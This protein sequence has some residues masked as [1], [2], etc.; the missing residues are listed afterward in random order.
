[1]TDNAEQKTVPAKSFMNAGPT[2]HYRH[3]NVRRCWVLAVIVHFAACSFW[4]MI[5]T[6]NM[7]WIGLDRLLDTTLWNLGTVVQSPLSIFEYPWQIAVLGMLMGIMAASPVVVS[8]L[9]SF[10]FSVLMI[11]SVIFVA[12]LPLFGAFLIVSCIAVAC[13][14]LRFRSRFIAILLC[15]APQM[16]YWAVFGGVESVDP[17]R[18]GFSYAPW[19]C[20]WLDGVLIAGIVIGVGHYTRYRP[21]L[22]WIVTAA[23][24]VLAF[25]VFNHLV[26]FD[27]LDY[28][29]YI[30]GNNPEKVPVFQDHPMTEIIDAAIYDNKIRGYLAG[31]FYP[32]DAIQLREEL[33][34]E[35]K[36]GLDRER[37]PFWFEVPDEMDYYKK[38]RELIDDQYDIFIEK[39]PKSDRMPIA[40]YYKGMLSEY[41]PDTQKFEKTEV[42]HFCNSYP[43][44]ETLGVWLELSY[45]HRDSLESLEAR[46]RLAMDQAGKGGFGT[47]I[48]V[49]QEA[50]MLMTSRPDTPQATPKADTIWT[51][52][53]KPAKTVMTKVKLNELRF[54]LKKLELLIGDHNIGQDKASRDRL[55]RFVMLDD[56]KIDYP[57]QV[58]QLLRETAKDDPLMDNILLARAMMDNEIEI[59]A[60]KL[61]EITKD[62]AATDAGIQARYELGV[63]NVQLWKDAKDQE[64]KD[65]YLKNA[66]QILTDFKTEYPNSIFVSQALAV[67]QGLPIGD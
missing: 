40:L 53:S 52:F 41:R 64:I 58:E 54:R 66:R 56:H 47:A 33:K 23:A 31:Q 35:L 21:G 59:R 24:L 20:A 18:W 28:Q 27:E 12:K 29:L 15:M 57:E 42:L 6:G 32:T 16:I 49:C 17:I 14:P 2:L 61:I 36:R 37:W 22:V 7:A 13:R 51:A 1:M 10:R 30:A 45:K 9:L 5:L 43:H 60:A 67:L 25:G 11:L 62:Y 38:R 34:K 8:Q 19:I 50:L 26:K 3:A 39:R 48:K 65:K 4:S 55:A 46:W 44:N 63:L